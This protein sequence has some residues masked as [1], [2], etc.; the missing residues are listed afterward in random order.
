MMTLIERL[1]S[2]SG[3]LFYAESVQMSTIEGVMLP[4]N[5]LRI[6]LII[7]FV[8]GLSAVMVGI[9]AIRRH[10][11]SSDPDSQRTFDD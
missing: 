1:Q 10:R 6:I 8:L 2:H 9:T 7:T 11:R 4:I 3:S 5:L